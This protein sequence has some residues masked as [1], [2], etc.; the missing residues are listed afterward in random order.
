MTLPWQPPSDLSRSVADR[1]RLALS[2]ALRLPFTCVLLAR[3]LKR[4][5]NV[6]GDK[7]KICSIARAAIRM[8]PE[9]TV[10]RLQTVCPEFVR[11]ITAHHGAHR[12]HCL[13]TQLTNDH[14]ACLDQRVRDFRRGLAACLGHIRFAAA[15]ATDD[16]C[17]FTH[18]LPS[19]HT[20]INKVAADAG[21]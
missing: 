16:R 15:P 7:V 13:T 9:R 14:F 19:I 5:S 3:L 6:A 11:R 1:T 20:P 21:D 8:S 17:N 4:S 10:D 12:A 18:P 2:A